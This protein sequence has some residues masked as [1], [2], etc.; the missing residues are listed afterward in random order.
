MSAQNEGTSTS[1]FSPAVSGLLAGSKMF[2]LLAI[3]TAL[4]AFGA[5]LLR[6]K[7]TYFLDTPSGKSTEVFPLSEP[8]V[9]P[10]SLVKWITQAVTSAYTIDFYHYQDNIDALQQYF[11]TEGYQNYLLALKQ[12]GSLK[13]IISDKLIVSAVAMDTAVIM[14]EGI[15]NNVYSWKIQIPLLLNYQ[16]AS[17]SSTQQQVVVNVLVTRVPT[18]IAPK[19][20]GISQIVDEEYHA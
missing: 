16:G 7:Q 4:G 20:I 6:P 5:D 19:G 12:S 14:Q 15:M 18:D 13:K 9:T 8:N 17:T 3:A 11:T 10:S 1:N 2:A